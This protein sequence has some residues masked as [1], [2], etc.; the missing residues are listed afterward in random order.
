MNSITTH[1]RREP[2][3]YQNYKR[4]MRWFTKYTLV[5]VVVVA[6]LALFQAAM[7]DAEGQVQDDSYLCS[8]ILS[9]PIEQ[10]GA[11]TSYCL[12]LKSRGL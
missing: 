7:V 8:R 5:L 6:L 2:L 11:I 3:E 4:V 12:D 9:Y 1:D 10:R